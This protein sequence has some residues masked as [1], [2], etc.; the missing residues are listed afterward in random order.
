[1]LEEL[2][3]QGVKHTP[4]QVVAIA[5][6]AAGKVVFLEEGNARAG[7][8]HIVEQHGADFARRG[9]PEERI[10]EAVLAAATRGT[11]VGIQGTRPIFEVDF[12]GQTRRIA[13]TVGAN[14][15]IV[16]ANPAAK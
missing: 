16:G 8:R 1:M 14:G 2:A 6:D 15:F 13:V 11:Q 10:P 7:L 12:D 5:R 3:Q 4:E 9:I